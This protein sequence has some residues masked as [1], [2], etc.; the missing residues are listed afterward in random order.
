[1][2]STIQINKRGNLSLPK[3]LM[4]ML[5]VKKGG[6]VLAE[7]SDQGIVL[8][9]AVAFPVEMYSDSRMA[10]FNKAEADLKRHLTKKKLGG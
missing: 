4:R 10:E 7:P 1:M 8:K 3:Q 2:T 5:G 9:P 6:A